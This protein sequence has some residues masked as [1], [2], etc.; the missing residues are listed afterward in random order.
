MIDQ[1]KL[2]KLKTVL[3]NYGQSH[4]LTFWDRLDPARQDRFFAQINQLDF[5][6]LDRWREEFVLNASPFKLPDKLVPAP[7]Y[8]QQPGDAGQRG[9]Y[10]QARQLGDKLISQGK[11]RRLLLPADREPGWVSTGRKGIFP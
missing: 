5:A 6:Q 7:F 10:D 3:K 9:K 4:I 1:N 8:A 11:S 2:Q